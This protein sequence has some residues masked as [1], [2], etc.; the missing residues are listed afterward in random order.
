[1]GIIIPNMG[2]KKLKSGKAD[3]E[4]G[5]A[6]ALF[7]RVQ[8]RVLGILFGHPD[9][10]FYS[11]EII[12]LAG[13]GSGAVQRELIRLED[14]GILSTVRSG[15]RKQYRAN[16]ASPIFKE[17]RSLVLKT[18]GLRE[19]I[20][21]ALEQFRSKIKAAFVYGSIAKGSDKSTSD[22]DLIVIGD[23]LSYSEI[24]SA[25]QRAEHALQRSINPNLMSHVEWKK[26]IASKNSFVSKIGRR[27][28]LFV[29]GS[30]DDLKGTE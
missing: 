24:Y 12:R 30:S 14:A 5:L 3:P 29:I 16:R 19:P 17:L 4:S 10:S 27:P 21:R 15:K 13:S 22:I 28:K 20:A 1:L 7:S 25:L 23:G 26:K 8:Q 2:T 6:L 9:G 11:S 18:I